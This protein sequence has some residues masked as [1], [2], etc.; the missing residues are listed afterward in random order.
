MAND[1]FSHLLG[2]GVTPLAQP[3]RVAVAKAKP[4][5]KSQAA[6]REAASA[7]IT[8]PDD[9]LAGEPIELLDPLAVLSFQRP[10]VQNGVFRNLRLGQYAPDARLD[11]HA[12]TLDRARQAVYG[13]IKDCL[14]ADV[15]TALITHGKSEGRKTPPY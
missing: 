15:R 7:E 8:P 10:G 6:R 14:A 13:F 4:D 5:S 2:E 11:L 3:A 1:A 9:P 12:L